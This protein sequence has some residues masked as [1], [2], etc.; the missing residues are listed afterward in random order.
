MP[1]ITKEVT[2]LHRL[3]KAAEPSEIH[4]SPG[5]RV[6]ILREWAEFYLIK[7]TDGKV[8]NVKKEYVDPSA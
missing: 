7:T 5:D 8:L 3:Q 6:T 4:F 1:V 2:L